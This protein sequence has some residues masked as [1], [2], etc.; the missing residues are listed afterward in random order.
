V[1][2]SGNRLS[3]II[4]DNGFADDTLGISGDFISLMDTSVRKIKNRF[5]FFVSQQI[6]L[7]H[8]GKFSMF[9]KQNSGNTYKITLPLA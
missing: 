2:R 4:A 6:I 9:A 8:R 3:I 7:Q 5:L 1:Y